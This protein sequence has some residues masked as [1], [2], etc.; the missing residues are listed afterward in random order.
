[1][2]NNF[3]SVGKDKL[4]EVISAAPNIWEFQWCYNLIYISQIQIFQRKLLSWVSKRFNI[5]LARNKFSSTILYRYSAAQLNLQNFS[6]LNISCLLS[7]FQEK[8]KLK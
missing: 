3:D 1:M 5:I 2:A 6:F 4:G 7:S 8:L